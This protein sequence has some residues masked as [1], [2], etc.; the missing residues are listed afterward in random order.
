[1]NYLPTE[2]FFSCSTNS[3]CCFRIQSGVLE[4]GVLFS[5]CDWSLEFRVSF[6]IRSEKFRIRSEVFEFGVMFSNSEGSFEIGSD[7]FEFGVEF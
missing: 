6:R 5:I 2:D 1:M 7:V 4:F 3:K